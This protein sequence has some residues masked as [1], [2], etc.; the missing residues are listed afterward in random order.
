MSVNFFY[1]P[2]FYFIFIDSICASFIQTNGKKKKEKKTI[3]SLNQIPT[4]QG[5][6]LRHRIP[7]KWFLSTDKKRESERTKERQKYE[8]RKGTC[9]FSLLLVKRGF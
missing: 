9:N 5:P 4:F 1:K 2:Q 7:Q 6:I 3:G 8:T